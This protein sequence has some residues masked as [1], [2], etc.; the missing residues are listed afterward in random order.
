[1][2]KGKRTLEKDLE[3]KRKLVDAN[4]RLVVSIAKK[5]TDRGLPFLALIKEGNIGLMKAVDKF[6][7]RRGQEFST[8]AGWRIREAIARAIAHQGV[9]TRSPVHVPS[10]PREQTQSESNSLTPSEEQ[11]LKMRFGV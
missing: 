1:M 5:Y 7:Y 4:F 2:S 6:E 8:Y 10:D 9:E 11:I 3:A